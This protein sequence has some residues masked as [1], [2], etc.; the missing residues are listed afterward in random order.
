MNRNHLSVIYQAVFALLLTF[1][2]LPR[3][4]A[5]ST[6]SVAIGGSTSGGCGASCGNMTVTVGGSTL[7]YFACGYISFGN[8]WHYNNFIIPRDQPTAISL[9]CDTQNIAFSIPAESETGICHYSSYVNGVVQPNGW[10][11]TGPLTHSTSITY[12][13]RS[14]HYAYAWTGCRDGTAVVGFNSQ[15]TPESTNGPASS[16]TWSFVGP[17]LGCSLNTSSGAVTTSTNAGSITLQLTDSTGTQCYSKTLDIEACAS[18]DAGGQ[19]CGGPGS[20]SAGIGSLDLRIN[21]GWSQVGD[22]AGYMYIKEGYPTNTIATPHALHYN[23]IRYDVQV[24]TNG[25]GLFQVK[26]PQGLYAIMVTNTNSYSI[27]LFNLTNVVAFTNGGYALTNSAMRTVAISNP[28]NDTNQVH[29]TYSDET[30]IRSTY[31]YLWTNSAWVL[32][33]G[34]GLRKETKAEVWS[35][36]NTVRT[37]TNLVQQGTATPVF[38]GV[39]RFG[40]YSYGER[41]LA[42]TNGT[43]NVLISSNSYTAAG[44]IQQATHENGLWEDYVYD[45]QNRPTNI[46]S[47]FLN[48]SFTTNSNL[49]YLVTMDY[50]T[51]TI[52]G[53]GDFGTLAPD[54]PRCTIKT[55]LGH[56][57]ARSYYVAIDGQR[58]DI[59]C[60]TPGASWTNSDNLV[61]T[62]T[63]FTNGFRRNEPMS[64]LHPDGTVEIFQY[65]PI[66]INTTNVVLRG[67]PDGTGTNVD[68]GTIITSILNTTGQV[69]SK[70]EADV[71]SG[72]TIS[73]ETYLYDYLGRLTNTTFLDGTTIG[74]TFD[75]CTLSSQ[76]D[77]DGTVTTYSYDDLKRLV[78]TTRNGITVS[79]AYDA[80]GNILSA[81]RYGTN[82]SP[83]TMSTATFDDSGRQTSFIDPM[84]NTNQYTNYFDGSGQLIKV[85]TYPD[86]STRV[87]TYAMD[88]SLMSVSGTAVHPVNYLYGV[89][90]DGGT[91]RFYTTEV[92]LSA[93]GGTNEWVKTY[94]D[95]IGRPY[96]TVYSGATNNPYAIAYYNTLGQITNQVDPDGV[97]M[98]FAYNLKGEQVYTALDTNQ[99]HTID[100]DVDSVTFVTSDVTNDNGFS[101]RRTSTYAFPTAGSTNSQ[102]ISTA[103]TSVD[104]LR[105]WNILYNNGAGITNFSRTVYQGGGVRSVTNIA[106]D[107]SY[108]V[109]VYQSG[110]IT[111]ETSSN[112]S[113][114]QLAQT[115]YG[116]DA[117]YRPTTNTDARNGST[118]YGYNNADQIT[119]VTTPSPTQTTTY[120]FDKRGRNFATELPDNTWVT[121]VYDAI[122][123]LIQTYGSRTYAAGYGHDAQGRMTKMTNW[124]SAATGAG[125]RVTT[126]NYDPYR[127]F[128]TNKVYDG[129]KAG[130]SYTY[131]FAGRLQTRLWARGTNTTYSYDTV[132]QLSTVTYNDG[133][134]P[135][136]GYGY[137]RRGRQTTIT[138]GTTVCTHTYDDVGDL[139]IESYSGGP[140][141]GISVTNGYDGILRRTNLVAISSTT[142]L[143]QHF[144]SYG[145]ASRLATVSDGTN[146]A[147]YSYLANSPLISQIAFTNAGALRM[148][149]TKTWDFL[150]RLLSISSSNSSGAVLDS[151]AY[152]YNSANQRTSVTNADGSYWVYQYDPLGQVI[153]GK[154]FWSDGTPVAGE[155]FNYTFDDIGNRTTTSA[156]GDQWGAN[157][158]YANY[159]ANTLNQYTNRT[160]PGGV[161]ILGEA[162]NAATVTVNNQ[163]TYRHGTFYRDQ[164]AL[165]NATGPVWQPVTN[166]AVLNQGTN[167]DIIATN[168]GNVFLP[169]TPEQFTYDADGNL[170]S[171]GRWTNTWDAENRLVSTQSL[172]NGPAG[173]KLQLLFSY[174][175]MSRRASK[176]VSN[177]TGSAW[178]L[179]TNL[180]FVY[181]GWNLM[182][183]L[184]GTNNATIRAYMWGNDLSGSMRGA[185][186]VGG[187]LVISS[188]SASQFTSFDGN[189]NIVALLATGTAIISGQYEYA[190]FGEP[191]GRSGTAADSN[192]LRFATKYEDNE[193]EHL[194]YGFRYYSPNYGRWLSRDPLAEKSDLNYYNF[195]RNDPPNRSDRLGLLCIP[196]PLRTTY[197]VPYF[198]TGAS[199]LALQGYYECQ[200]LKTR[201][202]TT[203]QCCLTGW[204]S[205]IIVGPFANPTGLQSPCHC[206]W[207]STNGTDTPIVVSSDGGHYRESEGGPAT[208]CPAWWA[209]SLPTGIPTYP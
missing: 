205:P 4:G 155:Q 133:S 128:L 32:T 110:L 192:P 176:I 26:A 24:Y 179:A 124:S 135:S 146:T 154:K 159:I 101:V 161:D 184:N 51:N 50:T 158:R 199:G 178:I 139:L 145:A 185:G 114:T 171:D 181:D 122:G 62:T 73:S 186:G 193:T 131:T 21:L 33:S 14:D 108:T 132:G 60:V 206:T 16:L 183:E 119:S 152:S 208:V 79:N 198:Y 188:P 82:G 149:T 189:G 3:T 18:C 88:G 194:Y 68:Q 43:V 134:T 153:S 7:N 81:V 85:T 142:S 96:K 56:E 55:L 190:P 180:T 58:K 148:T 102:L 201:P 86:T 157:L 91:Q 168:I 140:L 15:V 39:Q 19:S 6:V 163:T 187:A 28:S 44:F 111:S 116:Y 70:T 100:L 113:G 143:L 74:K 144:Y 37:V 172:T 25:N 141:N 69:L 10:T 27:Q 47:S 20:V 31:D 41:L 166:L 169:Q 5:Q 42:Q 49:C 175:Y 103:E 67:H 61:T 93:T 196:D 1:A 125:P 9:S 53:S 72:I 63:L 38:Q 150:N 126:W 54:L 138:N 129:N 203:W 195:V 2:L 84:S 71:A 11:Y 30:G 107:G 35:Q 97:S 104:G 23:F 197:G 40:E 65:G 80:Y 29:V 202:K 94:K 165:N 182:G 34:N 75:C 13:L 174:D 177:R 151:H 76:Q 209:K 66:G 164:L 98:L 22:T 120:Y 162:T 57:I 99:N 170:T 52:P 89:E 78:T 46:F 204:R 207:A 167:A 115:L 123:Q 136:L 127:G 118:I 191:F 36:T 112:A 156:G 8:C 12:E 64:I 77:R 106:Q 160:V 48:Q 173:S 121:N 92:K 17:D 83:I 90:S 137:D 130:P 59:Q 45:S 95:M 105:K 200:I 117:H 147:G 87:E 109:S